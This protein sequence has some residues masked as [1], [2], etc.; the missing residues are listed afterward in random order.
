MFVSIPALFPG[1][2]TGDQ[3]LDDFSA[4]RWME[5]EEFE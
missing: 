4:W 5:G 3:E 2:L 1:V